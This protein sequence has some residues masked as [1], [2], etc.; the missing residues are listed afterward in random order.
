MDKQKARH[1]QHGV[2]AGPEDEDH[3]FAY[4][5]AVDE[6]PPRTPVVPKGTPRKLIDAVEAVLKVVN[7]EEKVQAWVDAREGSS[8]SYLPPRTAVRTQRCRQGYTQYQQTA[9]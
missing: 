9:M 1:A 3:C 7:L 5:L 8:G 6:K 2:E 4:T